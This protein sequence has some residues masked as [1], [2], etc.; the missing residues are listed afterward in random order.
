MKLAAFKFL[1]TMFITMA[2][3][4][5]ATP[6]ESVQVA[7]RWQCGPCAYQTTICDGT[8]GPAGTLEYSDGCWRC[9]L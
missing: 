7:P 5:H 2:G 9:C 6:V 3:M 8:Y 4:V 1:L